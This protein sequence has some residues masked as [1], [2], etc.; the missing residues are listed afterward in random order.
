MPKGL[1]Q[2]QRF[3][4]AKK[5]IDDIID[6][7]SEVLLIHY[8]CESFYD[9][10]DGRSPR[11]TSIAVKYFGSN[12]TKSFS[13]HQEGELRGLNPKELT[14]HYDELERSML[15]NF[16]S[17]LKEKTSFIWVHWNMRDANY[18]FEAI[19]HRSKVL[20]VE[21][22]YLPDSQ[23]WDLA[24]IMWDFLGPRFAEKPLLHGL[25]LQNDMSPKNFLIGKDEADAFTAGEYVKLHQSTLSKVDAF[26]HIIR[27]AKDDA[28]ISKNNYFKRRGLSFENLMILIQEHPFWIAI[29]I[30]SILVGIPASI[31]ALT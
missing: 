28:L 8:S 15:T 1:H 3:Q 25:L 9:I 19:N 22:V 14:D 30:F 5:K 23:K 2:N 29:V 24:N 20:G 16:A 27:A 18:G 7:E 6:R 17:F 11:T 12:Q 4:A 31:V 21:P 26:A 13:I 10:P